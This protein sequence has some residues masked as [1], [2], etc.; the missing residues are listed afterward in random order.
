MMFSKLFTKPQTIERYSDAPLLQERLRYLEFRAGEGAARSTLHRI[1]HH[2][3]CAIQ[4]LGLHDRV[5]VGMARLENAARRWPFPGTRRRRLR[6]LGKGRAEFIGCTAHWLRFAG[7]FEEPQAKRHVHVDKVDAYARWMRVE[8][9]LSDE[10]IGGCRRTVEGFLAGWGGD[11]SLVRATDIDAAVARDH[12]RGCARSTVRVNALRLRGFLRFA[13]DRGWC[14]NGLADAVMPPRHHPGETIPKGLSRDET[15]RLLATTEGDQATDIRDRAMLLMLITYGL[16]SGEVRSLRLEDIGW[17][18]ERVRVHCPKTGRTL[19][20]ALSR[21][22][23]NAIL[24][25]LREV[26]PEHP[27]RTLF[28]TRKAPFRPLTAAGLYSIVGSR[29]VRIGVTDGRRGPHALRHATAQHLL[30]QGLSMKAVGD[31]LGHRSV[32]ATSIYAKVRLDVLREVAAIDLE[33]LA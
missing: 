9:G 22:V 14:M 6:A 15:L 30:D 10:T 3:L 17:R 32:A 7:L 13:E 23:G 5:R 29:L 19:L 26:R 24:R 20:R 25:Y 33:G 1:A 27:D 11:L 18:E 28:L 16:R 31:H 12:A 4:L 2:Q 21:G 8:R